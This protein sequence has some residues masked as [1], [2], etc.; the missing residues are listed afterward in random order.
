MKRIEADEKLLALRARMPTELLVTQSGSRNMDRRELEHAFKEAADGGSLDKLFAQMQRRDQEISRLHCELQLRNETLKT[1]LVWRQ[2]VEA[3]EAQ[4]EQDKEVLEGVKAKVKAYRLLLLMMASKV[5]VVKTK[6]RRTL[7]AL[8]RSV[9]SSISWGVD[10]KAPEKLAL[11]TWREGADALVGGQEERGGLRGSYDLL[12]HLLTF[13]NVWQQALTGSQEREM[14]SQRLAEGFAHRVTEL[15][16]Q[17]QDLRARL[18]QTESARQAALRDL[19]T[20][21]PARPVSPVDEAAIKEFLGSCGRTPDPL[22]LRNVEFLVHTIKQQR[23]ELRRAREDLSALRKRSVSGAS[24]SA[25]PQLTNA[26]RILAPLSLGSSSSPPTHTHTLP[27][28]TQSASSADL[29]LPGTLSRPGSAKAER[30]P[31]SPGLLSARSDM[32]ARSVSPGGLSARSLTASRAVSARNLS[33]DLSARPTSPS[34]FNHT[35]SSLARTR[36][37]SMA[38]LADAQDFSPMPRSRS[39]TAFPARDEALARSPATQSRALRSRASPYESVHTSTKK[40]GTEKAEAVR[41]EVETVMK[42]VINGG[43]D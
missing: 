32:S 40:R 17:V 36:S 21:P 39:V 24:P 16:I 18:E 8:T 30:R 37:A 3:A 34:A 33:S 20:R 13:A 7:V 31:S 19:R 15:S 14:Q 10:K 28:L 23:D 6:L 9:C 42:I 2:N 12:H 38:R 26:R 4:L 5:L 35:A 22:S 29:Q 43:S 41:R 1:L 25:S 27:A 11:D